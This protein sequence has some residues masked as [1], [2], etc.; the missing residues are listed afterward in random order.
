MPYN[1]ET[2]C[3]RETEIR[4][5][6]ARLNY[7]GKWREVGEA[8]VALSEHRRSC[9]TCQGI[10]LYKLLWPSALVELQDAGNCDASQT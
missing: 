1:P 10:P 3:P 8:F 9:P 6:I 2:E 5:E 4:A 7:A